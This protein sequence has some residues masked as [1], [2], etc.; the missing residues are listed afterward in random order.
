MAINAGDLNQRLRVL[1]CRKDAEKNAYR[2]EEIGRLWAKAEPGDRRN[3][4]SDVGI[5][6]RGV[7]FT[8]RSRPSLTLHQAFFWRGQHCFLTSAIPRENNR[9]Y[10]TVKAALVAPVDCQ[11][12]MDR[13]PHGICFPGIL[14]EK[15][16]GHDQPDFHS[17]VTT[18][19]VLVT[20]KS[21]ELRPGSWLVAD[22]QYYLVLT[23]HL[24][25]AY[26]NEFEIR[27][28]EDC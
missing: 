20:P 24:L 2:W 26:K 15:Y 14:T 7:T 6:A 28:K 5:G 13:D 21:V 18:T 17:E 23:P 16:V 27:R 22:G 8:I 9:G 10:W 25:D 3:L 12:D 1:E 11:A 4:F 19:Y